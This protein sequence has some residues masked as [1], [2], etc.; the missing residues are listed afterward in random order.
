M[1]KDEQVSKRV[2]N[3][4][5]MLPD[6]L[7]ELVPE[8]STLKDGFVIINYKLYF[9]NINYNT[10]IFNKLV[11]TPTI[12]GNFSKNVL[13]LLFCSILYSFSTI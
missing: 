4:M 10:V 13:L 7:Q 2:Q 5:E 8:I 1:L 12:K 9:L 11:T 3:Y 6:I